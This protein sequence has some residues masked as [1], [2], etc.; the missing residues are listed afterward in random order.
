MQK[1]KDKLEAPISSYSYKVATVHMYIRPK[2]VISDMEA[3]A[4]T[5]C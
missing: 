5:V 2:N 4:C 3:K 1:S